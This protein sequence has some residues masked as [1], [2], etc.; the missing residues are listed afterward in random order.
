MLLRQAGVM[1][2]LWPNLK[3]MPCRRLSNGES[4][5]L[6]SAHSF[7]GHSQGVEDRVLS[8]EHM[9][10][11]AHLEIPVCYVLIANGL[12]CRSELHLT[13]LVT[14]GGRCACYRLAH[15]HCWSYLV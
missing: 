2:T 7:V 4:L 1:T 6:R 14:L 13:R 12:L 10:C 8:H 11:Y 3:R 15:P 5:L 9:F